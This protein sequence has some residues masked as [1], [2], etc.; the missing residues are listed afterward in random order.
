LHENI[1]GT[2]LN[3]ILDTLQKEFDSFS[4]ELPNQSKEDSYDGKG[5]Y[6]A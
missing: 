6:P 2:S 3:K 5:N 4:K 1:Y